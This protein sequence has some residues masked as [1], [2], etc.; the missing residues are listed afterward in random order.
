MLGLAKKAGQV[1]SGS[2]CVEKAVKSGRASLVLLAEDASA[3]TKKEFT[4][5]CEFYEVPCQIYAKKE[6]LGAAIGCELRVVV[7][8][9]D[10]GFAK[11]IQKAIT[12]Q[13]P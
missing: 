6:A 9:M 1:Q 7:A 3:N 5:M 12:I 13:N 8:V 10:D 2:F 4:N 11:S